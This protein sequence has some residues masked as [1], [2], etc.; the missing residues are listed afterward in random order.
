MGSRVI[1][2][3]PGVSPGSQGR[4]PA[5]GTG[6]RDSFGHISPPRSQHSGIQMLLQHSHQRIGIL[7]FTGMFQ[8]LNAHF[9]GQSILELK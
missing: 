1:Q 6:R 2:K 4:D 8:Q 7:Q 5:D 9:F 3:P